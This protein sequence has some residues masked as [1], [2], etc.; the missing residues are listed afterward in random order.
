MCRHLGTTLGEREEKALTD[1]A[2]ANS[3]PAS[4]PAY[5]TGICRERG[6]EHVIAAATHAVFS[7]HATSL[8]CDPVIDAVV[9]SNTL[10]GPETARQTLGRQLQAVDA[11]RLCADAICVMRGAG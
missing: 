4:S 8:L 6:A 9:V 1:G 7:G 10:P 3:D 2:T 11:S 5:A